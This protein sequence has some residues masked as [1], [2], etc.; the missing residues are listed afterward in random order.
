MAEFNP[1]L[2][3]EAVLGNLTYPLG[4]MPKHNGVRGACQNQILVARSKKPIPNCHTRTLFGGT[5]EV[6]DFEGELVVGAFDDEE[7]FSNSTSGVM[8]EDGAPDVHWYLFDLYHPTAPFKERHAMLS[9]RWAGLP[10]HLATR[11]SVVPL[12]VIHS[13]Q[14]LVQWSDHYLALGFE[15]VV[16]KKLTAPYKTGR[17]TAKEQIFMRYCPWLT[18]EALIL[19]VHEGKVNN[20]V[21]KTNELGF[22]KKSTHKANIAGSGQAGSVTVKD[23]KTGL[24]HSMAVPTDA[25]QKQVWATQEDYIGKVVRYKFKPPVIKNGLPRF[26]QWEGLRSE[27]DMGQ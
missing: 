19:A 5:G 22:L 26:P 18:S 11:S 12:H 25:L 1:L 2:A 21:S 16:L 15:G 8:T 4:L 20:N 14:E 24:Q 23:L 7:V 3:A 6:E 10:A 17:S 9:A 27:L 13:D